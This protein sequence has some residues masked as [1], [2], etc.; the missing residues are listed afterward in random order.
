MQSIRQ[1][2]RQTT[3][4][5]HAVNQAL[6]QEVIQAFNLISASPNFLDDDILLFALPPVRLILLRLQILFC[7]IR[8]VHEITVLTHKLHH[9]PEQWTVSQG[10]SSSWI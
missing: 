4:V 6:K 7:Q 1:S 3:S 10:P 8:N 9:R 5:K 2:I